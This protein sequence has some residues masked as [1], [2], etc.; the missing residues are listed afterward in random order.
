MTTDAAAAAAAWY[1]WYDIFLSDHIC[2]S[3]PSTVV[4]YCVGLTDALA[5]TALTSL[6]TTFVFHTL[7]RHWQ[8]YVGYSSAGRQA[9]RQ[10]GRLRQLAIDILSTVLHWQGVDCKI[11][12]T[13]LDI[14]R[15]H[16]GTLHRFILVVVDSHTDS[17][18]IVTFTTTIGLLH[19]V[20]RGWTSV[21][22]SLSKWNQ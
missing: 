2:M 4:C 17:M 12:K 19:L 5:T 20:Q 10:T 22:C 6:I 1:H 11:E 15:M 9:G 13:C 3:R 18:M 14:R 16:E 8:A 7:S 21:L